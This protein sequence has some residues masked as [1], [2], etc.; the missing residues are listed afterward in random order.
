MPAQKLSFR[1]APE[2]VEKIDELA[3]EQSCSRSRMIEI[4]IR[5]ALR[6][7]FPFLEDAANISELPPDQALHID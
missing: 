2:F 7:Y 3:G 5:E 6:E 4:L 1:L